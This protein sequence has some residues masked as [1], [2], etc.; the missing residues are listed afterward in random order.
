MG[1]HPRVS[2]SLAQLRV[3]VDKP[4]LPQ[5]IGRRILQLKK[6]LQKLEFKMMLQ[7]RY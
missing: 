3:F 6:K 1:P 2:D 7:T 4:G 5:H